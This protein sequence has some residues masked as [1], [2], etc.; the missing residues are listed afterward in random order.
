MESKRDEDEKILKIVEDFRKRDFC[1]FKILHREG[2]EPSTN[3]IGLYFWYFE[4]QRFRFDNGRLVDSKLGINMALMFEL[5]TR[6]YEG[7]MAKSP[8]KHFNITGDQ[9]L[10]LL[11]QPERCGVDIDK[12]R[13]Y[14]EVYEKVNPAYGIDRCVPLYYLK[15]IKSRIKACDMCNDN[16]TSDVV[17]NQIVRHNV[18][19]EAKRRKYFDLYNRFENIHLSC[20]KANDDVDFY[21]YYDLEEWEMKYYNNFEKEYIGGRNLFL[22]V[23]AYFNDHRTQIQKAMV[24]CG[25]VRM[26]HIQSSLAPLLRD[27]YAYYRHQGLFLFRRKD[28][29]IAVVK[30]EDGK[31]ERFYR[32]LFFGGKPK[33]VSLEIFKI[34]ERGG[35]LRWPD[36]ATKT[37]SLGTIVDDSEFVFHK[38]DYKLLKMVDIDPR[39]FLEEIFKGGHCDIPNILKR[40]IE[41]Y[42]NNGTI[43][44]PTCNLGRSQMIKALKRPNESSEEDTC[45]ICLCEYEKGNR[46]M[47]NC[48]NGH[49][50]HSGCYKKLSKRY[51]EK[52]PCPECRLSG[53]NIK[54]GGLLIPL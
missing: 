9:E 4:A 50:M 11:N 36:T 25:D 23:N 12:F 49:G 45:G 37:G 51:G 38:E 44:S 24:D 35:S 16:E 22:S 27:D 10:V 21:G 46:K 40:G 1:G 53:K 20:A 30:F 6:K 39:E 8:I 34:F 5:Y 42:S 31:M 43:G 14:V 28:G 7:P 26:L 13:I 17:F 29:D 33:V 54:T 48:V 32:L 2:D 47:Y 19:T 15:D 52:L 18:H 41:Y 3:T